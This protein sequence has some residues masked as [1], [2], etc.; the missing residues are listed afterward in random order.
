ELFSEIFYQNREIYYPDLYKYSGYCNKIASPKEKNRM[1]GLCKKVLKYLEISKEWKK[2]E[3]AYDECILLNYWIYDTL[4]KYFNHD[5]DDMNVAFGTLQFIW[6][7]LTKD[8]NSTSFYK[9]CI[10]LFDMLKYKDWKERKELYD[11]YV[12]Y[13]S[14]YSTANNYDEK[15]KEYYEYIE[16]KA[17][18]YEHFGSLCTSDNSSCPEIYDKCMPYNPDL[19]LHTIKCHNDIVSERAATREAASKVSASHHS[20]E[21]ELVSGSYSS[22]QGLT[23]QNTDIGKTF[24]HSVLGAAPVL[25][26]ASVLYKYTPVGSWIRNLG[27]NNPN[28]ISNMDGEMERFLGNTQESGNMFFDGGENYISYQPM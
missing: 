19:V 18:L 4:D 11:Y 13:N 2:N 5:T 12:N 24:G 3:S 26:T 8:Y 9:K 28:S 23:Q 25:L 16:G 1:K 14:V 7:P 6:D 22:G 15:C 21:Q 17:S 27:R 10:P 20:S